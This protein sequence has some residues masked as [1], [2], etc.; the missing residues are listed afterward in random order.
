MELNLHLLQMSIHDVQQNT[1]QI[2]YFLPSKKPRSTRFIRIQIVHFRF[3][4]FRW[5]TEMQT[6]RHLVYK[7]VMK[8]YCIIRL[9]MVVHGNR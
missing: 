7:H 8:L 6:N 9:K 5:S 2:K 1:F 3:Y 4:G